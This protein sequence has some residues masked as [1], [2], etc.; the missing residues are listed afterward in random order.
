VALEVQHGRDPNY[1]RQ[2]RSVRMQGQ[3]GDAVH[4]RMETTC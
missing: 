4:N 2:P 3:P 1:R